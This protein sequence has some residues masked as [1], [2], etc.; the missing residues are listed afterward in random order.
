MPKGLI[1]FFFLL[2]FSYP[3]WGFF[4]LAS[5]CSWS[6]GKFFLDLS[7]AQRVLL[8]SLTSALLFTPVVFGTEG[9]GFI[10]HWSIAIFYPSNFGA[11]IPFFVITFIAASVMT[12]F[13]GTRARIK[14]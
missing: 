9:F 8:I 5:F 14:K 10:T 1:S 13:F 2:A 3:I 12:Y 6:E 11:F 4:L 7:R